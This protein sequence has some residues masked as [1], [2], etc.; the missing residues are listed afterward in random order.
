MKCKNIKT[1]AELTGNDRQIIDAEKMNA[2]IKKL[3]T[4]MQDALHKLDGIS[5]LIDEEFRMARH[6][7]EGNV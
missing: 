7:R 1:S 3:D 2:G 5:K 4:D 6:S